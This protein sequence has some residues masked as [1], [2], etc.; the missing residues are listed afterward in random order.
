MRPI[1][2]AAL[3]LFTTV[4]SLPA[5]ASVDEA[6]LAVQ[7]ALS[8]PDGR[9]LR[10]PVDE[11]VYVAEEVDLRRMTPYASA[12]V[13]WAQAHP[14]S[15]AEM[16]EAAVRIDPDLPA[17]YFMLARRG[18]AGGSYLTSAKWYLRGL[19]ASLRFEGTRRNLAASVV[20]WLTLGVA[21]AALVGLVVLMLRTIRRSAYDA[22]VAGRMVFDGA[23]AVVFG[24]VLIL[25]PLFAGL[26]PE[27]LIVYLS[28]IGWIY[29]DGLQRVVA[30]AGC[31]V[32]ALLPVAVETWQRGLI[33]VPPVTERVSVMLDERQLNPSA[34]RE[35]IGVRDAFTGDA[36]FHLI[37][38]ELLRMHSAIESA[39]LEFQAA[40]AE[41]LGDSRPFVFLGNLAIED[42]NVQLAIQH[43]DSAIA[44]DGTTALAYHNLSSAFDLNRRFQQGDAARAKAR[45]LA[46]G[47]SGTLGHRGRDPRIRYPDV[48]SADVREFVAGLSEE[49]RL[50]VGYGAGA[51]R[52]LRELLSPLSMVFWVSGL[53]G[54]VVLVV[55]Q[56]WFPPARECTKCGKVYR[57]DDE[58]GESAVY[59]RQCVSV[60][61]QRDLVPI[62]QQSAKLAQVRRWERWTTVVRR[63]VAVVAP[64]AYQVLRDRVGLGVALGILAWIALAGLTVWVP[65]FLSVIEPAMPTRPIVAVLGLALVGAWLQGVMLSWSRR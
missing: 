34:L 13:A 59:C 35:L 24:A 38:G 23:N 25:L 46:G 11:L 52:T 42:G 14:E 10:E 56:R 51:W 16:L 60:F 39:K 53:L 62:D 26:G 22:M 19:A 3:L 55:R 6:W 5:A 4:A 15:G 64:G 50:V 65:R 61:L 43:Y 49:E 27:W 57:L 58:P 54:L 30:I 36:T 2:V 12:L 18:W 33:R 41:P 47:R 29:L 1:R 32:L 44:I 63:L 31:V 20:I 9:S 48:S 7:E 40:A 21:G 17:S 28:V 8:A 45:E 37:L